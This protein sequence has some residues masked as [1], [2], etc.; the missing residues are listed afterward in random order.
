MMLTGNELKSSDPNSAALGGVTFLQMTYRLLALSLAGYH[1]RHLNNGECFKNDAKKTAVEFCNDAYT[2]PLS[3]FSKPAFAAFPGIKAMEAYSTQQTVLTET[4]TC[5]HETAPPPPPPTPP[6]YRIV[7]AEM[8]TG[9]GIDDGAGNIDGDVA[10][11]WVQVCASTLQYGLFEQG[12][13]FGIPDITGQFVIDNRV[14]RFLHFIARWMYNGMYIDPWKNGGDVMA[15]PKARLEAY[16]AYRLASTTVWGMMIANVCGFMLARAIVPL[17]VYCLRFIKVKTVSGEEIVMM[18]PQADIPV[19]L[20]IG[21]TVVLSYWLIWVDPATQSHYPVTTTCEEWHGLG[22][23]VPHGAYVTTWGKRRF[24]R[25]GEYV[26]GY[27]LIVMLLVFGFQQ[28]AGRNF[29]SKERRAR[30]S[31]GG[32]GPLTSRSIVFFWVLFVLALAVETCFAV[33]A[34]LTGED[35][36]KAAEANDQTATLAKSFVKDCAMAVWSAFWVGLA[37]GVYRQR[38]AVDSLDKKWKLLWFGSTVFCFLVPLLQSN[39][40][41]ADE[42]AIAFR[43]NRGTADRRRNEIYWCTL[44]FTGLL[45]V[46]LGLAFM[47]LKSTFAQT[48]STKTTVESVNMMKTQ[49]NNQI[50]DALGSTAPAAMSAAQR[51][52]KSLGV[53]AAPEFAFTISDSYLQSAVTKQ[54]RSATGATCN[55]GATG[56]G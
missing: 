55:T 41:L 13:L 29:V 56:K 38:W 26:I 27:L 19:Y 35:W 52:M 46:P 12:R 9:I 10:A 7:P 20:A 23:L 3:T 22:V 16:T 37:I 40:Y 42:I 53:G 5:T 49:L 48:V 45:G 31:G 34:G 2:N 8:L 15:D 18:R 39:V 1:D 50:K 54:S 44:L 24:D 11:P 17:I 28:L 21:V 6:I 47:K 14:D 36:H 33:Q 43:D 32:K 30:N 51:A 4:S 25:L